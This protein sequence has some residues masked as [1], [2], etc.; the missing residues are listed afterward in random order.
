MAPEESKTS[1]QIAP[2][3]KFGSIIVYGDN[4]PTDAEFRLGEVRL[5]GKDYA[6]SSIHINT[7]VSIQTNIRPREIEVARVEDASLTSRLQRYR[8]PLTGRKPNPVSPNRRS[9]TSRHAVNHG[10][11]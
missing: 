3:I 1:V 11:L 2:V 5:R 10:S 4:Y 8:S 7:P 6:P 9:F